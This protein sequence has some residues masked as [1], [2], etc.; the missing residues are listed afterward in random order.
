MRCIDWILFNGNFLL[1]DKIIMLLTRMSS[2]LQPPNPFRD[3]KHVTQSVPQ[4]VSDCLNIRRP[5][6]L[7]LRRVH[8][9]IL[10]VAWAILEPQNQAHSHPLLS[11]SPRF[12]AVI[13]VI[14][15]FNLLLH[16][17]HLFALALPFLLAHLRFPSE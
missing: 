15:A 9:L 13:S 14:I 17:L 2:N 7:G 1:E 4:L 11:Q 5:C 6:L 16:Y 3:L 10:V 12:I 8:S